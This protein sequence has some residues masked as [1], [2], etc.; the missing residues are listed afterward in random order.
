MKP[1]LIVA[2]KN[3]LRLFRMTRMLANDAFS[4]EAT[5]SAA[6]LMEKL[7]HGG[8][9]IVVLGDGLEE[10]L[11]MAH[12]ILLLKSCNANATIILATDELTRAEEHSVRQ[13][14]VFYRA[15]QPICRSG[16]DELQLAVDCACHSVMNAIRPY[17]SMETTQQ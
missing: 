12:L 4:I 2:D 1:V 7:L 14:G 6:C 5:G 8:A 15:N 11:N 10:G 13:Q 16:W 3:P 17:R 9:P